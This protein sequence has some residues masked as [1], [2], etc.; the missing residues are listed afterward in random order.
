[1]NFRNIHRYAVVVLFAGVFSSQKTV[2]MESLFKW[3]SKKPQPQQKE[4]A[5]LSPLNFAL[6]KLRDLP[7]DKQEVRKVYS[8]IHQLLSEKKKN[9]QDSWVDRFVFDNHFIFV[10][11]LSMTDRD[12]LLEKIAVDI[13]NLLT[14]KSKYVLLTS[15]SYVTR[16]S[17]MSLFDELFKELSGKQVQQ[18]LKPFLEITDENQ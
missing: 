11:A 13:I 14:P 9:G 3:F 1:M 17:T 8:D 5:K 4:Q 7:T 15:T 2:A 10:R 16:I 12:D 6:E 18:I